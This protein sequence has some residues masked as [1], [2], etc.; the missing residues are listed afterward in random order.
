MLLVG[1]LG[2]LIDS[3]GP[4]AGLLPQRSELHFTDKMRCQACKR[5]GVNLW[6]DVKPP[7]LKPTPATRKASEP[8]YRLIDQGKAHP[9]PETMIATADNLMVARAAYV[10]AVHFY[11]DHWVSLRQGSFVVADN[12]QDGPPRVMQADEYR[13][14][15]EVEA[16]TAD[17]Q[18]LLRLASEREVSDKAS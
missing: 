15:R 10:A 8:N 13:M 16:G 2:R 5:R 18:E 4:S 17:G 11:G 9:Y 3:V 14:M 12:R 1:D 7:K 6:V